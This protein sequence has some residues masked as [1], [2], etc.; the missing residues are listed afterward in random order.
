MLNRI[1]LHTIFIYLTEKCNLNCDYCYFRDKRGRTLE[2]SIIKK[3]LDYFHLQENKRKIRLELSGGEPLLFWP[4][5]KKIISYLRGN[6][7]NAEVSIQTNGLLL[8]KDKILFIKTN[9]ITLEIGI[10]GDYDSTSGHRKKIGR[11]K[12]ERLT[13][14]IRSCLNEGVDVGCTMTVHPQEAGKMTGNFDFIKKLGLKNIDVTPAAFTRWSK[15]SIAAFEG[16]Y[17]DIVKHKLNQERIFADEDTIFLEHFIMDFSLHPPGYVFCGDAYLCLPEAKRGE[18]SI[19]N[20]N[21]D[22]PVNKKILSFYIK[23]YKKYFDKSSG[24]LTYRDYV[25]ASFEIINLLTGGN[26]LNAA[27]MINFHNFLKKTNLQYFKG[28]S[29]R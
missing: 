1:K 3:F 21:S 5:L 12:F 13:N 22:R 27:E 29:R 16:N 23:Q 20:F 26:Y 25:S 8:D 7:D 28:A 14:N 19:I 18:C 6:S 15:E 24:R 17:C 9:D 4:L 2:F 10:D 11:K